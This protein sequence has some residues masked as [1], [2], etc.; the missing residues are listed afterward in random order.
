MNLKPLFEDGCAKRNT[1][2]STQGMND[3]QELGEMVL[4]PLTNQ[5]YFKVKVPLLALGSQLQSP[6]VNVFHTKHQM[7][8]RRQTVTLK[9]EQMQILDLNNSTRNGSSP[10]SRGD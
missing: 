9:Q 5:N 2:I 3:E 7:T 8:E 6:D 4:D 10:A 1:K